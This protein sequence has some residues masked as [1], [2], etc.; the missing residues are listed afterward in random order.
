M[1]SETGFRIP[2]SKSCGKV[3]YTRK[4]DAITARNHAIRKRGRHSRPMDL[5][6]YPCP[7]CKGWHL[8]ESAIRNPQSAIV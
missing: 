8:T 4:R 1:I 2:E 3:R 7:K 6:A 5:Y